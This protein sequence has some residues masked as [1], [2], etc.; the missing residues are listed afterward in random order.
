MFTKFTRFIFIFLLLVNFS[1]GQPVLSS[2]NIPDEGSLWANKTINDTTLQPGPGGQNQIWNF[3]N[4]FVYPTVRSEHFVAPTGTA[5]DQLFPTA[6][7]K[8]TTFFGYDDYYIRSATGL[9]YLGSKSNAIELIM[10]NVQNFLTVPFQYGD[11]V[12]NPA[13]T[14][15]GIFGNPVTGTIT[16]TA[17]GTGDLTLFTGSFT[18]TLRVVTDLNLVIGAG[19][20]VDTYVQMKKYAWYTSTFKAPV[21]QVSMLDISGALAFAH[22]KV[23]TVSTLTTD[24]QNPEKINLDFIINPNPVKNKANIYF[25]SNHSSEI[26]F[27]VLDLTGRLWKE[28][29]GRINSGSNSLQIDVSTLPKGIYILSADFGKAT[30]QRRL[31]VD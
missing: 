4:Y 2:V 28:E 6:N 22:D 21:F 8:V 3:F 19:T 30:K 31:I 12:S 11:V 20:G 7:L 1:K 26:K 5:N 9:Q 23:I 18:N 29:S 27:K 16:V 10:T 15:T 24:V 25:N 17:D 14:G 13:V